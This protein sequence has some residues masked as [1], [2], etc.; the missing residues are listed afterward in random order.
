M[1][2]ALERMLQNLSWDDNARTK[3]VFL[4]LDAPAHHENDII[5]SLQHSIEIC[6]Q[7]GIRIIPVAASGTDKNTE[8]MLR[9]FAIA[10]GGT[11]VFLTDHSGVGNPHMA[12]SVG[13]YEVELL[14]E[15]LI[16]L[17]EYYTE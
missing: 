2:T 11:Y 1:H 15:L 12:A 13:E 17:I 16:R 10:T 7:K 6:A 5:S 3:L 14:N 8:F 4:V 9:F